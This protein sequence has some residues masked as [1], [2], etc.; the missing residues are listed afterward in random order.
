MEVEFK[1]SARAA[2][3]IGRENVATSQGAVTELV[4]NSY[5]ADAS[6]CCVLFLRRFDGIPAS[7][8]SQELEDVR[9]AFPGVMK[10]Y[11]STSV[12]GKHSRLVPASDDADSA[13]ELA[14]IFAD[15]LDMWLIDNGHGMST[16]TIRDR[17]M[18]IGTDTKEVVGRSSMGRAVTGAKG[19]GRFALDRLGGYATMY[20]GE[21]NT[22]TSAKWSV[23]WGDFDGQ[24]K[25]IGQVKA[26]LDEI[27]GGLSGHLA[28]EKITRALP[29]ELPK[30]FKGANGV[31]FSSGTAIKITKL[32]DVWDTRDGAKLRETLEALLPPKERSDFGIW[33]YDD[34][35][36]EPGSW[37]DNIPP[38]QFD[39]RLEANVHADGI[40]LIKITRQEID[41][42]KIRESFFHLEDM[43][44]RARF[45]RSDLASDTVDYTTDLRSLMRREKGEIGDLL[46]IGPF[47][48]TLY[49][50]KLQNPNKENL[51]R[52]PQ[53]SFDVVKRRRWLATSGGVR[54]YRDDF[55]VRPYGEPNTQGSD[56]LLLGQRVAQN[57]A[58]VSRLNWRVPPQQVAGTIHITKSNNP[59]LADQSNREGIMNE[60]VFALFRGV[61]LALIGEFERDRST[62]FNALDRAFLVDNPLPA[63][64]EKGKAAAKRVLNKHVKSAPKPD[65][66]KAPTASGINNPQSPQ[67]QGDDVTLAEA[68]NAASEQ[69]EELK[70]E[71]RVMRGMATL[72]TVL[73]SLTHELKQ[74]QINMGMRHKRM[75]NSLDQVVDQDKLAKQSDA[76]NPYKILERWSREDERVRRWVDFTLSSVEPVKRRR[77]PIPMYT[78]FGDLADYWRGFLDSRMATLELC[79]NDGSSPI[80]LAHEIDLDSMFYNLIV[81]SIEAFTKKGSPLTRGIKIVCG[82]EG[83][84][85]KIDYSDTGPGLSSM[86]SRAEEIFE[87]GRSS[88]LDPN[89]NEPTG[90]GI[91]MW[92]L[93]SIVDDYGGVAQISSRIGE[94]GFSISIRLPL[95][96]ENS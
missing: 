23:A 45:T 48:F 90:T 66:S 35:L 20:S 44:D 91:G 57:P 65:G 54:L 83:D 51:E 68:F 36:E 73:V 8:S 55:R 27:A 1:V 19:I 80:L 3:L 47:D 82:A 85:V 42:T 78:Y 46:A 58:A 93:K 77:R 61:I 31:R 37:I 87:F 43:R 2:R 84:R 59:L 69:N 15:V 33:I 64:V 38:D 7:L 30:N 18:V 21:A 14:N 53:K 72:G 75:I 40:V 25:V 50:F 11:S 96:K 86:F 67:V 9:T 24:G 81:N 26:Q 41:A 62:L 56:W 94:P 10:F 17:W 6:V 22:Q 89:T 74:I 79:L 92:L 13:G 76:V 49:F 28:A 12:A 34:R 16:E 95:K 88:K 63:K 71:L 70:E 32:N 5:D 60:R 29:T 52:Y 39:Y 4:K